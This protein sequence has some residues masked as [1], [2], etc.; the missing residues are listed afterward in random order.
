[1]DERVAEDLKNYE[2]HRNIEH[3]ISNSYVPYVPMWQKK[4]TLNFET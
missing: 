2:P 4:E 1:M 3:T